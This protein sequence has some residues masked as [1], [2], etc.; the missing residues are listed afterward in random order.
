MKLQAHER[1]SQQELIFEKRNL[2]VIQQALII[3]TKT[4]SK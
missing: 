1:P 3:D 4:T 2:K